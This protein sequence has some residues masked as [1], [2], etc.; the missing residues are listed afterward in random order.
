MCDLLYKLD[1][2]NCH[3]RDFFEEHFIFGKPA[4]DLKTLDTFFYPHWIIVSNTNF[5]EYR[6]YR[7]WS[8]FLV[9]KFFLLPY[10]AVFFC[11]QKA[12]RRARGFNHIALSH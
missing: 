1:K 3:V 7:K 9:P 10:P 6:F 4:K 11:S 12:K 2:K 5:I 8:I